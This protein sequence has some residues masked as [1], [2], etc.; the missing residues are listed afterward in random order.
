MLLP[1]LSSIPSLHVQCVVGLRSS[2]A[3]EF[4]PAE[5]ALVR[6]LALEVLLVG[7]GHRAAPNFY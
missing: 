1:H 5:L 6:D 2:S 3:V 4:N 7:I